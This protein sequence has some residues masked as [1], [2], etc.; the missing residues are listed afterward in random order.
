MPCRRLIRAWLTSPLPHRCW[1]RALAVQR[2]HSIALNP[3]VTA[4]IADHVAVTQAGSIVE[5]GLA[6]AVLQ[7]PQHDYARELLAAVP[8]VTVTA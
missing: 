2:L 1:P 4:Y 3:G 8:R 7:R 5:Q 6:E